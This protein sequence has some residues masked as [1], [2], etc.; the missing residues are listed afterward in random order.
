M[1]ANAGVRLAGSLLLG[2]GLFVGVAAGIGLLLGFEPARL[3]AA[4]LNIA[5]YKLTFVAAGGLLGA[6]AILVRYARRDA[7][8]TSRLADNSAAAQLGHAD[9]V[10]DVAVNRRPMSN[11]QRLDKNADRRA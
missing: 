8:V 6:G 9:H 5:A 2:L 3:P 4:L 7:D 1:T 11:V 10:D